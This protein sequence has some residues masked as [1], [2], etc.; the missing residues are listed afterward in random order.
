MCAA[1]D[2][3]APGLHPTR[4]QLV[5][6]LVKLCT[7]SATFGAT[8]SRYYPISSPLY[9]RYVNYD[10]LGKLTHQPSYAF[11]YFRLLSFLLLIVSSIFFSHGLILY[12]L[13]HIYQIS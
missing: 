6:V 3:P 13:A 12:T 4:A 7:I 9:P 2:R 1:R 10:S 11:T 8:P 5:S